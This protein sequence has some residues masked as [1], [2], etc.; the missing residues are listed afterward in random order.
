MTKWFVAALL[1]L[2]PGIAASMQIFVRSTSGINYTLEVEPSDSI[3]TVRGK[4]QDTTGISS[5]IQRLIFAGKSL[6]DGRTL[7]DYNI[8]KE[9]TLHLLPDT[10]IL[11][12]SGDHIWSGETE[13]W[14]SFTSA[15]GNPGSNWKSWMVDGNLTLAASPSDR[16]TLRLATWENGLL[17]PLSDFDPAQSYSWTILTATGN[18]EGFS[19]EQFE[20]DTTGFANS[21]DGVFSLREGS[22][23]LDYSAIPEPSV[24]ALLTL[25]GL[26]VWKARRKFHRSNG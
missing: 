16:I 5:E 15:N 13:L 8:Q 18:V 9:S 19:A 21:F 14:V 26:G 10:T 23:V 6:Q 11:T 20:L 7:S 25:M 12:L 17:G 22:I 4:I 2:L 24:H 3:E 1:F